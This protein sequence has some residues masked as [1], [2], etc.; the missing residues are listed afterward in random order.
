MSYSVYVYLE[1]AELWHGKVDE[2]FRQIHYMGAMPPSKGTNY[3]GVLLNPKQENPEPFE[4]TFCDCRTGKCEKR[5]YVQPKDF[6]PYLDVPC[7][8]NY[9][10]MVQTERDIHQV[11]KTLGISIKTE[12]S[13]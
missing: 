7:H 6:K 12:K 10:H 11:A 1:K 13:W 3:H 4:Y 2:L 8:W 5:V 9:E